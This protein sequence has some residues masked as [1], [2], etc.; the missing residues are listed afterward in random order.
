MY[1]LG[2]ILLGVAIGATI[3]SKAPRVLRWIFDQFGE[4]IKRSRLP[5]RQRRALRQ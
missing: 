4:E 3:E 1:E 5:V 2:L